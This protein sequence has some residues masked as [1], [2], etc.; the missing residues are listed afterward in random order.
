M[1]LP[2]VPALTTK[3]AQVVEESFKKRAISQDGELVQEYMSGE[4]GGSVGES[5]DMSC[6][7]HSM[8]SVSAHREFCREPYM[9]V[10]HREFCQGVFAREFVV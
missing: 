3:E 2:L 5:C 4:P 9:G 1:N 6:W 8:G 7:F 10:A